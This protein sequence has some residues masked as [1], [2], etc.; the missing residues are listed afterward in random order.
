[1]RLKLLVFKRY[2]I[3]YRF[4]RVNP[5]FVIIKVDEDISVVT[6]TKLLHIAELAVSVP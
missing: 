5:L 1:M 4:L 3:L 6:H 2:N